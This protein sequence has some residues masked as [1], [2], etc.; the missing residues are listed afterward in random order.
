MPSPLNEE[1]GRAIRSVGALSA[2][3]LSLVLAVVLGT[4]AGYGVDRWVGTTP[5]GFLLGFLAG[6]VAGMRSVFKTVASVARDERS[7]R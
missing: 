5:W 7:Q 3:G 6:V 1:R 4:A 2:V